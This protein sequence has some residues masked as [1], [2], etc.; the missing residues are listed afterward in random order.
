MTVSDARK[1]KDLESEN[2]RIKKLVAEQMLAIEG[3]KAK[4]LSERAACRIA[5]VSRRIASYELRQPAKDEE[6]GRSSWKHQAAIRAL[7][8]AGLPSRLTRASD[9]YGGCGAAWDCQ[10]VGPAYIKPGSPWQNGF[11]ESFNGNLRDECL[12]RE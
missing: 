12:N 1:L 6:P 4:G 2:T 8:I 9:G 11:V 5:G 7:V 10:N 3:L